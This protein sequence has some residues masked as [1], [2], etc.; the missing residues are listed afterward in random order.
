[1][2]ETTPEVQGFEALAI[3]GTGTPLAICMLLLHS[4]PGQS[5]KL[6]GIQGGSMRYG[7]SAA[8]VA[9]TLAIAARRLRRARRPSKREKFSPIE[10]LLSLCR[11]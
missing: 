10:C 2:S 4:S 9:G 6:L 1:M 8:S 11:G 3:D 7:L 5:V